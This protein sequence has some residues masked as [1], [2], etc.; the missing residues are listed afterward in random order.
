MPPRKKPPLTDAERAQLYRRRDSERLVYSAGDVPLR[1]AEQ[2][3][4]VGELP[5]QDASDPRAV[6]AALIR[7]AERYVKKNRTP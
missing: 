1:L 7:A 6:F 3:V 2:L 5:Q 4:E